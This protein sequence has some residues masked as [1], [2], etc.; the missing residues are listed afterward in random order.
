MYQLILSMKSSDHRLLYNLNG[1]FLLHEGSVYE[2]AV[3]QE[4]LKMPQESPLLL[5]EL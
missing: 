2:L 1:L 3:L 4:H 5:L